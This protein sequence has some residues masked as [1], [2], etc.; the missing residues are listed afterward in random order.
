MSADVK[1]QDQILSLCKQV[2]L[3]W[4]EQNNVL[5]RNANEKEKDTKFFW[6]IN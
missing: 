5:Y 3:H 2:S 4:L 1:T 6:N